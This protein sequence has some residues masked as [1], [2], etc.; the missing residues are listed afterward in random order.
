MIQGVWHLV[1]RHQNGLFVTLFVISIAL[2]SFAAGGL[3]SRYKVFPYSQAREALAGVRAIYRDV[4]NTTYDTLLRQV[5]EFSTDEAAANRIQ[6]PG[7]LT[8][9]LLWPGGEGLFRE[10]CPERG[11]LAVEF[12]SSGE[13]VHAYPYR[14][15]E[16]NEWE[17]L[18]EL[19]R[20]AIHPFQRPELLKVPK[21][22]R[23]Y[24]NGDLLVVFDYA[25]AIPN[26]GGVARIDRE[27]LPVW[28]REDNSHH[29]PTLFEGDDG[30]ELA[31]V[32]GLTS[33]DVSENPDLNQNMP[34]NVPACS[35]N[36]LSLMDHVKVLDGD[37]SIRQDI[38][39]I[40]KVVDSPFAALLFHSVDPCD[41]LH[42]NYIDR[43][44]EDVEGI[45]GVAPGDYIVS[46]R[47]I[48]AFG[49]MDSESGRMKQLVS[50]SFI[51]QHSVQH[52]KGS[53]FLMFDNHGADVNAGPSRVL[54]VDLADGAVRERTVYPLGDTP[55]RLRFYSP[56][57]G[58]IS[59]S[60]DRER[61]ILVSSNQGIGLE[62]RMADGA[63][64]NVFRNVHDLSG[65]SHSLEDADD[66][67]VYLLLN[68]LQYVE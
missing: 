11:C 66:R 58:N 15:D 31:L 14:L 19:P 38:R 32:P 17:K 22:V 59:I 63:V 9:G 42:L 5:S 44:R 7:S 8:S 2:A 53:Q 41:L 40:D 45:P 20:G 18:A 67:A 10:M 35:P 4:T 25:N 46:F 28:V 23:K 64:L 37:G 21:A 65:L 30:G 39:I 27:G 56:I 3:V 61:I 6:D 24:S 49:I 52:L 16:L 36:D 50:G 62:V 34:D 26:Y 13:V 48:S 29:W 43:I 68:D 1:L 12:S 57:R 60:Q 55:E 51:H 47:S 54:L 33:E